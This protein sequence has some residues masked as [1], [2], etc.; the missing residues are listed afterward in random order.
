MKAI[1]LPSKR[2]IGGN[3]PR[4]LYLISVERGHPVS[5]TV[6]GIWING[7]ITSRLEFVV[8]VKFSKEHHAP[9]RI[10]ISTAISFILSYV[11]TMIRIINS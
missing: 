6:S 1:R 8:M 11:N 10:L 9:E 3:L 7:E 2:T 5:F 4:V